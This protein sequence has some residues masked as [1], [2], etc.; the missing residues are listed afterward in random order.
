MNNKQ[1]ITDEDIQKSLDF[2]RDNAITAAQYKAERIY[3]E[4]YRKSLKAL[5][6]KNHIDLPVSAQEREAYAS[7]VYIQHLESM[8]IAIQR[9]EKQRF[10]RVSAEA[11]I[12]AWR[13]MCSN[14][15]SIKL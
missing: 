13:T 10:L 15:R 1:I 12:E 9:D 8:K 3:L 6:M 7:P 14:I 5:L 11:K 4:E 2:L